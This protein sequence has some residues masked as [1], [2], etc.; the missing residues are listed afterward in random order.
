MV[1][2]RVVALVEHVVCLLLWTE[3]YPPHPNLHVEILT[4]N[5][6][7]FPYRACGEVVKVK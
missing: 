5:V 6:T 2:I 1:M 4:P 7:L 3:S